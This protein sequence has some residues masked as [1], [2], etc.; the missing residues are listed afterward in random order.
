MNLLGKITISRI[1]GLK[2]KEKVLLSSYLVDRRDLLQLSCRE[3]EY[4]LGRRIR[5][6]N[7]CPQTVLLEAEM[8]DN[9]VKTN[10][11]HIVCL[12]DP[13][14]P[15]ILREIYDPP[16]LLYYRGTLP[17]QESPAVGVVGTRHASPA[18]DRA[19][20]MLG[21]EAGAAG[22]PIISGLAI[23]IDFAAH[24]GVVSVSGKTWGVLGSG[25]GNIYPASSLRTISRMLEHNG[26]IMS[27]YPP[28]EPPLR[29]NFPARNRIISGL[30]RAVCIIE[31]PERSGALI[32]ASFALEQGRDV[33]VHK[34][35]LLSRT[36][37]GT[38]KLAEEGA[39]VLSSL[40]EV[41]TD[42]GWNPKMVPDISVIK[43]EELASFRSKILASGSREGA[44]YRFQDTWFKL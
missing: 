32:T 21:L 13:L 38:K 17:P 20:F 37:K 7:Y 42:W 39:S 36:S 24:T 44:M 15:A 43:R 2:A 23:G 35:G 31:A 19:S 1:P 27:E 18:S 34:S 9:W 26:G 16:F 29:W 10:N 11:A 25:I 4:L 28:L 22:I 30:C 12:D 41:C 6:H 40:R 14:Y 5:L 8:I 33:Y 3:I